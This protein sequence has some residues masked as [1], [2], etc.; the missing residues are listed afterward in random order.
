MG[1]LLATDELTTE[2]TKPEQISRFTSCDEVKLDNAH[3]EAASHQRHHQ[4]SLLPNRSTALVTA[5]AQ[6]ATTRLHACCI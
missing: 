4:R 5:F 6:R 3:L 1:P 2:S